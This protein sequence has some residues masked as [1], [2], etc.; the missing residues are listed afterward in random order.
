MSWAGL[1]TSQQP[2]PHCTLCWF[3]D[4]ASESGY[5]AHRI[6]HRLRE[7]FQQPIVAWVE[8]YEFFGARQDQE[9]AL[10]SYHPIIDQMIQELSPLHE[11]EWPQRPHVTIHKGR[12]TFTFNWIGLHLPDVVLYWPL[13]PDRAKRGRGDRKDHDG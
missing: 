11:S 3:P 6:I 2:E 13:D 1:H 4:S 12:Q 8:G 10:L 5:E 9:V 7:R